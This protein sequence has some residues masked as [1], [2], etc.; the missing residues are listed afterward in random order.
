V[1]GAIAW[2]I[3]ASRGYSGMM[4]LAIVWGSRFQVGQYV[5]EARPWAGKLDAKNI[6]S[7]ADLYRTTNVWPA[8]LEFTRAQWKALRPKRIEGLPNFFT[9][10][11]EILLRNPKAPRS[12]LAGVMGYAFDWSAGDLEFGGARFGNVGVRIKGNVG[13]LIE[14]KRP[15]KVDL[16]HFVKGQKIAGLDQLT[17]NNLMWDPSCLRDALAYGLFRD[18]GV[19]APRTAYAWVTASVEK[20]WN[21]KPLGLFLLLEPVNESFA[22]ERFGTKKMA[23]FKPVTYD[24]FEYLG[25]DWEQYAPIYD[26]KTKAGAN[27]KRRVVEFARLV[28]KADDGEFA[29]RVGELMD[30][31]EVAG[32]LAAQ[33]LLA[34][35]DGILTTGQNFYMY[36]DPRSKKIGFIPWDLDCAWGNFWIGRKSQLERASIWHPWS[37]DNRFLERLFA[38]EEFRTIYRARLEEMLERVFTADRIQRQIDEIAE[39]IREPI[40]A[41]SRFRLEKFEQEVGAKPV[42]HWPGET[43]SGVNQPAYPYKK[44]VETRARSVRSQLH[45]KT[46]GLLVPRLAERFFSPD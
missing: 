32:F 35:Y 26:L 37:G 7:A 13:A 3:D 41:E 20:K 19:P 29:M 43:E 46:K 11:G 5:E 45:G 31:K 34:S 22:Q 25:E 30:L 24:L 6:S 12:G 27:E 8:H 17:F 16:N 10:K 4:S 2:G 18:G 42:A 9:A 36:I 44:F 40:G 14:P 1:A 15:F 38:V 33:V 39:V 23:I 28:S 21:R